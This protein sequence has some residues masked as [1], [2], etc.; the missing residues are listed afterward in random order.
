MWLMAERERAMWGW[1]R[2]LEEMGL[3]RGRAN[4]V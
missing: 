3:S 4:K 2:K 1:K